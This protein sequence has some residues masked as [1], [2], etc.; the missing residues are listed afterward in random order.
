M[1]IVL[2]S[3]GLPLRVAYSTGSKSKAVLKTLDDVLFR[4]TSSMGPKKRAK[5]R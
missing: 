3:F 2:G 4:M 5:G 1:V